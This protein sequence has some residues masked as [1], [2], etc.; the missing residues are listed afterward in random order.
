M[1]IKFYEDTHTYTVGGIIVPSVSKIVQFKLKTDFSKIPPH[2]LQNAAD[3]GTSVHEGVEALIKK[4]VWTPHDERASR[5]VFGYA[6]LMHEHGWVVEEMEQAV[7]YKTHYAGRFDQ[8]IRIGEKRYLADVK[9]TYKLNAESL[10][11]QLSL[12]EL[13]YGKLDG[14]KCIWLEKNG[15]ANLVEVA[16]IP[17]KELLEVIK[18]YEKANES[19]TPF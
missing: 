4:D 14:L 2:I 17:E 12:Y 15:K 19:E 11:W 8:V 5:C 10:S 1:E 9:T 18:E 16:R 3:F 6:H 7:A 13:A